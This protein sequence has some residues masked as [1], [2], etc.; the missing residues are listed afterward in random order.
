MQNKK[1]N[2]KKKHKKKKHKK[3]KSVKIFIEGEKFNENTGLMEKVAYNI[4]V[5]N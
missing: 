2:K 1:K 5:K 3:N 4:K